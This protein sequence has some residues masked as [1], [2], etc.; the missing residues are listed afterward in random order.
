MSGSVL[1]AITLERRGVPAAVTGAEL[2]INTTGRG[3]ARIQ[4]VPDFPLIAISGY[5]QLESIRTREERDAVAEFMARNVR[6][7][8]LNGAIG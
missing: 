2:F 6:D 8:L 7:V 1:D 5:V 4:G 3:M